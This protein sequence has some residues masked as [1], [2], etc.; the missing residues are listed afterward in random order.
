MDILIWYARKELSAQVKHADI[1]I[2]CA[3]KIEFK[4]YDSMSNI[5]VIFFF[6]FV[7]RFALM[8]FEPVWS[9]NLF[10][11]IKMYLQRLL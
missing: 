5:M 8:D 1:L 9:K 3:R 4:L 6:F 10:L 7:R 2:R 11:L